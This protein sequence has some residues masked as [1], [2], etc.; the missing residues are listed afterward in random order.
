MRGIE[1]PAGA[2]DK[3]NSGGFYVANS[4]VFTTDNPTRDWDMFTAFLGDQLSKAMPKL[5]ITKRFENLPGGRITYLFAKSDRMKVILDDQEKYIAVFLVADDSMKA[6]VFNTALNNLK[7][8]IT[9][10]YKGSVFRR[11]NYRRL[12]EVKDERL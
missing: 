4:T 3:K 2:K 1:I 7:N 12:S 10:G 6:L 5:E 11:I 8:I 9:F